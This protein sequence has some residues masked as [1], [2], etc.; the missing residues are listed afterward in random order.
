MDDDIRQ[1]SIDDSAN[2]PEIIEPSL[3]EK[4]IFN[5]SPT[6]VYHIADFDGPLDMLVTMIHDQ[7][8]AIEDL[9]ISEITSQYVE[10]I[11]NTPKEEL[12]YDYAGDFITMAAELL[13]LKSIKTLPSDEEENAEPDERDLFILKVKEYELMK[14]QAEKMR[15]LE[16]TNRFYRPPEYDEKDY[17][18]AL[19]NFNLEKLME[20]YARIVVQADVAQKEKIPKK[21]VREKFS[22]SE[23]IAHIE[24][25]AREKKE[26]TFTSL[27]EPDY[28]RNDIVTT[29]LAILELLSYQ[30]LNVKQE[31]L[32]GEIVLTYVENSADIIVDFKEEDYK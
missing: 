17:R 22:V 28:D 4:E 12:D 20:A 21:V 16:T 7:K 6:I 9:F 3:A 31:E 15:L 32:F 5:E 26:F 23:Q 14:E 29:F 19:V 10:I 8:I 24:S 30:K 27:F 18:V 13:Y 25:I 1:M 11:K 2:M